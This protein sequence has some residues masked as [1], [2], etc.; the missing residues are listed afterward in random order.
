MPSPFPGMAPYLEQFWRDIHARCIIYAANQLQARLPADLRARVEKRVFVESVFGVAR[1][2]YPDIRVVERGRGRPATTAVEPGPA[3][4]EP[5]VIYLPDEP[6]AERYIEIIDVGSGRR[7]VTVIEVLSLSNKSPGE[8]QELYGRKPREL[9][10]A[11]GQ[12]GRDRSLTSWGPG[13]GHRRMPHSGG[14]S[15]AVPSM[16]LPCRSRCSM[17]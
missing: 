9:R 6:V 14:V 12:F 4:A 15:D 2:V 7:V 3:A 17:L 16:C 11:T 8:G 1:S 10:D 13:V 5:L